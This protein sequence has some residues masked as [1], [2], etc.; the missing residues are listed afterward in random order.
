M[1]DNHT[2]ICDAC[3]AR[4]LR[5]NSYIKTYMFT[6]DEELAQ[7]VNNPSNLVHRNKETPRRTLTNY[8]QRQEERVEKPESEGDSTTLVPLH[9]GGRRLGDK[10]LAP[11][12]RAIIGAVANLDTIKNTAE[13]FGVS[14]HHVHELKHGKITNEKGV[15]DKLADAVNAQLKTPHDHAVEKLTK[16]ILKFDDEMIGGITKPKDIAYIA[17]TLSRIAEQ[18]SPIKRDDPLDGGGARLIVYAP[19]IKQENH[20]DSVEVGKL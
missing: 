2:I 15:D 19:S 14:T 18:T 1:L 10:N 12:A 11:E 20:Y 4:R 6:S 5:A 17:G 13:A 7:R 3:L 8:A 16:L 9:N